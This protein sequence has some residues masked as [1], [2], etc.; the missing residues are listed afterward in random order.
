MIRPSDLQAYPHI[1]CLFYPHIS[2]DIPTKCSY[3]LSSI[4]IWHFQKSQFPLNIQLFSYD[5]QLWT[6]T[7]HYSHNSR[8]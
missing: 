5:Q 6:T 1:T 7:N 4:L 2:H 3:Y 8:E